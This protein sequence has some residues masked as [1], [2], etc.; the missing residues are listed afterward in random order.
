M[1]KSLLLIAVLTTAA[2]AALAGAGDIERQVDRVRDGDVRMTFA[3]RPD[4]CGDGHGSISLGP[5]RFNRIVKGSTTII[6]GAG[7]WD[8]DCEHGPVRVELR[9]RD[10]EIRRI[11]T[12]V[13]GEWSTDDDV[14]DIGTV[15]PRDAADYLLALVPEV[16]SSVAEDAILPAILARDV[17]VWPELLTIARTR[18]VDEDARE[19]AV[20]W[21]GQLAGEKA[22]EG[23]VSLVDDDDVEMDIRKSAVFALS[24]Q[25]SDESIDRLMDIARTSPHPQLRKAALFWLAQSD[26]PRVLDTFEDILA[27]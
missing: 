23:L 27:N 1:R 13:G 6:N 8:G 17:V 16:R 25:E 9:V 10:G 15:E 18:S 19:A 26:D 20:F 24:Q 3:S 14:V 7:Y 22:T 4:A 11:R 2:P 21:L 5:N 12:R